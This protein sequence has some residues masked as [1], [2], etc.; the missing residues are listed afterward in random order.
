MRLA[1][2]PAAMPVARSKSTAE[3]LELLND[4]P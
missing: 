1:A 3:R 4:L 2:L